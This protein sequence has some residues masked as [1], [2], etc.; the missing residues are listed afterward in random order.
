MVHMIYCQESKA[1]S[2]STNLAT[3][4]HKFQNSNGAK[5]LAMHGIVLSIVGANKITQSLS[6]FDIIF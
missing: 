3:M 4:K 1:L 6:Y 2:K 5:I